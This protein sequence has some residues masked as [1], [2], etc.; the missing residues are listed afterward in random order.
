MSALDF[1]A[2][3]PVFT[4]DEFARTRVGS[5]RTVDSLLRQHVERGRLIRVRR[6]LYASVPPGSAP[7]PDGVDPYL[8]A[9]K[10]APDAVIS[11]HAALQFHGRA[12]ALWD[13]FTYT[14]T[15]AARPFSLGAFTWAPVR[16]PAEL[17]ETPDLGVLSVA[18]AGGTAR[19][20]TLER[21]LVDLMHAPELG[22][23]W[24]EVW[25]SLDQVEFFDLDAVIAIAAR[26]G[27]ASTVARVGYYLEQRR[28]E[29]FVDEHHLVALEA[30]APAQARYFDARRTPGHW[31]PRWRLIVPEALA[32]RRWEEAS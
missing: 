11:H 22:G 6:G 9:S 3:H 12:Y 32:E 7:D 18:H 5:P 19:V 1:F 2:A 13:R 10:A 14:T 30:M 16:P 8:V 20:T 28:E 23:G 31:V 15:A 17:A 4:R 27:T 21:A 29:L 25:R 24:E 26:L